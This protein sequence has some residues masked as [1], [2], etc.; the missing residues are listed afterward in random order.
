MSFQSTKT[1]G[2][3][4]G[5]SCAF[6]QWRAN[7]SHCHLLHGYAFKFKFIFAANKLDHRGWIMDF[8]GLKELR[9]ALKYDFDHVVA[10]AADDPAIDQFRTLAMAGALELRLFADGVGVEKFAKHAFITA[11]RIIQRTYQHD[12]ADRNLRV[13]SCECAE[14]AGNSAIYSTEWV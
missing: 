11:E 13:I 8:G 4:E 7:D 3:S 10:L 9:A 12:V 14:H 1:Y 2:H 5:L 6:R